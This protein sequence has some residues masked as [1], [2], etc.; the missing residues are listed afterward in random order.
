M[1]TLF[2]QDIL[3]STLVALIAL[4]ATAQRLSIWGTGPDVQAGTEGEVTGTVAAIQPETLTF[5]LT[6]TAGGAGPFTIHVIDGST[7]FGGLSGGPQAIVR[8]TA[9]FSRLSPGELV[10][11]RGKGGNPPDITATEVVFLGSGGR[12]ANGTLLRDIRGVVQGLNPAQSRFAM[13]DAKGTI[14]AIFGTPT[15]PVSSEGQDYRISQL[16]VGDQVRVLGE[17]LLGNDLRAESID[18]TEPADGMM[19]M[20]HRAAMAAIAPPEG[21]ATVGVPASPAM[22]PPPP[23]RVPGIQAVAPPAATATVPPAN[24]GS[25]ELVV[26]PPKAPGYRAEELEGTVVSNLEGAGYLLLRDATGATSRVYLDGELGVRGAAGECMAAKKL[27]PGSAV[28]IRAL[29][30]PDGNLIAQRVI[31][32]KVR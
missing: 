8:G 1:S 13:K 2:R 6:P 31:V 28:R 32:E 4:P 19:S 10:R 25:R 17:E 7:I 30:L 16:R 23:V 14:H 22:L 12:L 29:R 20:D 11:V 26:E 15:T 21:A 24:G 3:L 27:V 9:G 5:E 18:V